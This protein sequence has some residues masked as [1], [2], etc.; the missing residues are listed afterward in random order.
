M[1]RLSCVC[2]CVFVRDCVLCERVAKPVE[3]L[4]SESRRTITRTV[5]L[6]QQRE[7]VSALKCVPRILDSGFRGISVSFLRW[8]TDRYGFYQWLDKTRWLTLVLNQSFDC[9]RCFST[10][11]RRKALNFDAA[12]VKTGH[13]M[14]G[15]LETDICRIA[16]SMF[17]TVFLMG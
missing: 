14:W 13:H 11:E 7:S 10:P 5:G 17:S 4:F 3:L 9:Q 15:H 6:E 8:R 2:G 1:P 16:F 12:F